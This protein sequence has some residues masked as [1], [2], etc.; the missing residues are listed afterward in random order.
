MVSPGVFGNG[1]CDGLAL[2]A[3]LDDLDGL[4]GVLGRVGG[5]VLAVDAH[6][7]EHVVQP[8]VGGDALGRLEEGHGR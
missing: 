6:D 1:E 3:C 2:L 7:V 4:G 5:G 8:D